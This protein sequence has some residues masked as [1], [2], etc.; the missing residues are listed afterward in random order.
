MVMAIAAAE[1][2]VMAHLKGLPGL[3]QG[4]GLMDNLL[5]LLTRPA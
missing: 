4:E 1:A 3:L 5:A 2:S